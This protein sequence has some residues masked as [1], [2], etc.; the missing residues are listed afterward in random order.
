MTSSWVNVSPAMPSAHGRLT[1]TRMR[2]A[3]VSEAL[4]RQPALGVHRQLRHQTGD[5][6]RRHR[7]VTHAPLD[8]RDGP[9][10]A[11]AQAAS[12]VA[13]ER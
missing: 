2:P 8:H 4:T 10:P 13:R 11:S 9:G 5:L 7:V 12:G 3:G 1:V 6:L